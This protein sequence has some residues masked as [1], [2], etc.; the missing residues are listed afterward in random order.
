MPSQQSRR[1]SERKP[2]AATLAN[3]V[4][5]VATRGTIL[6]IGAHPDD[7]ELGAGGTVRR[8]VDAGYPVKLLFL[9][10]GGFG[11]DPR[12][13]QEESRLACRELGVTSRKDIVFGPFRDSYVP[14]SKSVHDFIEKRVLRGTAA[15]KHLKFPV[16]AAFIHSRHDTHQDHRVAHDWCVTALRR[17]QRIYAFESPSYTDQFAPTTFVD[18]TDVMETKKAAL[19]RHKSQLAL[20]RPY[21]EYEAMANVARFRGVR[22]DVKFAEAF[23]TLKNHIVP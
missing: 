14:N 2:R 18:I 22:I 4:P 8:F 16:F 1:A 19:A 10:K 15:S 23:E 13:R 12:R 7:I 3:I 11:C 5:G 17:V 20:H 6:F 9:T 21:M